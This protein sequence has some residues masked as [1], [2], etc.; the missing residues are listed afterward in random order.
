MTP[1]AWTA[2]VAPPP[3]GPWGQAVTLSPGP[4]GR[5]GT[6]APGGPRLRTH[7]HPPVLLGGCPA[8]DRTEAQGHAPPCG[9]RGWLS[10][11]GLQ[12]QWQGLWP[13]VTV[14]QAATT[15][16]LCKTLWNPSRLQKPR[17]S[18]L[19]GLKML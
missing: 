12:P 6:G 9:P 7:P 17:H 2:S 10:A 14:T 3:P 16:T 4:S 5:V 13:P 15:A 11:G 1:P 18:A 19:F 8:Q